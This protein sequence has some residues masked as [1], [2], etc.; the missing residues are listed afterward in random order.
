MKGRQAILSRWAIHETAGYGLGINTAGHL[1]LW[2][3]DG[4]E[5]DAIAAEVPLLHHT[6]YL[7]AATYDP[8]SGDATIR[9]QA[10]LNPY[11]GRLGKV[12]PFDHTSRVRQKLR[13]KVQGG[14]RPFRFGGALMQAEV[15]GEFN[16]LRYNGKIDR[17]GV[18]GPR[19][20]RRR[21]RRDRRRWRAAGRRPRSPAGTPPPATARTASTTSCATP[22]RTPCTGTACT[23]RSAP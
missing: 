5:T 17:C 11:N 3:G 12:A 9:Q 21:A 10:V 16:E 19:A 4:R 23:G 1:E 6:W 15:R 7:V 20:V 13:V 18:H 2:V 22:G 14:A 8:G